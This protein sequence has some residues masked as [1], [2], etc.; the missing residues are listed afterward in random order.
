M[1]TNSASAREK[2][3]TALKKEMEETKSFKVAVECK[4]KLL[5]LDREEVLEEIEENNERVKNLKAKSRVLK[6]EL[7]EILK[8]ESHPFNLLHIPP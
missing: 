4:R 5:L 3:R 8:T 7:I 1:Y 6:D 2:E